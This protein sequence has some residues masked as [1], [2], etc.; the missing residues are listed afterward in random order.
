MRKHSHISPY[1]GDALRS[2]A[3]S[4]D[5]FMSVIWAYKVATFNDLINTLDIHFYIGTN[6][7][8]ESRTES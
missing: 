2:Q 5:V 8:K 4:P 1:L 6:D 7:A 3:S